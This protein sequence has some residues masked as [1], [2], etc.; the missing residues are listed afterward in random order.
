M[1]ATSPSPLTTPHFVALSRSAHGGKRWQK[2]TSYEFAA[3]QMVA[4]LA[5]MELPRAVVSMPVAFV[6]SEVGVVPVAL[7]GIDNTCNLFV[8]SDGRWLAEYV[9]ASVRT[10]PFAMGRNDRDQLVL[11]IDENSAQINDAQGEPLFTPQGEPT[12]DLKQAMAFIQR[13]EQAMS[14]T[15]KACE[16]LARHHCLVPLEFTATAPDGR[17]R[18]VQGL[19]RID[20][21]ALDALSDEAFLE[22]RQ[23][24]ALAIAYAQA[25]SMHKLPV[26]KQLA[27]Q[28]AQAVARQ[29]ASAADRPD[30]SLFDKDGTFGFDA[31]R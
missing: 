9:P 2:F 26:L 21:A 12:E 6:R 5:G 17:E 22:L 7:L 11:C 3:A 24:G 27:A 1:T 16:A 29:Q 18:G 20:E 8:S 23:T 13:R 15:V 4:P 30:L 19:L 31:F 25:V 14:A 10:P 28:R